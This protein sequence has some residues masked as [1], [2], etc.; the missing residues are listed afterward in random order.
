[1]AK[2]HYIGNSDYL[3]NYTC[4]SNV[5]EFIKWFEAQPAVQFD[6]ETTVTKSIVDRE[7]RVMQFGNLLGDET[8]VIQKSYLSSVDFDRIKNKLADPNVLKICHNVSFEYQIMLKNGVVMENVWDTMIMEQLLYAGHDYDLRFYALAEVLKR[9]YYVDV[10]KAMQ[11]EFGDDIMTDEKLVYAA[12]DVVYLGKIYQDQRRELIDED[13]IQLAEGEFNE[14]EIAL[15]FADIEYNGMGFDPVKW[16]DNI[17]K[18][19]PIVEKAKKDLATELMKEPYYSKCL[20]LQVNCK[21]TD[22][23]GKSRQVQSPAILGE[24]LLAVNWNSGAQLKTILQYVFPDLE[25]GSILELKKYLQANDPY[26]PKVS[27]SGK[28]LSPASK[29]F[30]A[31]VNDYSTNVGK[32]SILK[33]AINKDTKNLEKALVTNFRDELIKSKFLFEKDSIMINWN[34]QPTKLEIFQW[35]DSKIESTDADVVKDH[36]HM[37]FF[38]AYEQYSFANSLLTKYGEK[39]IQEQVDPDGRVRTRFNTVLSTGR[40][41][42]SSPKLYWAA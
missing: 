30:S 1:M 26:A 20:E 11:T 36:A 7:L 28:P 40:V 15:A 27:A 3:T 39:F 32:F 34:S 31:Y 12:T 29:E 21:V 24:D 22:S 18:A 14:N 19:E 41:S 5:D 8:F 4:N 38:K 10:S 23:S 42:S 2:L 16:R 13:L 25:K 37:P 33:L 35:F 17:A 9:R 6:T